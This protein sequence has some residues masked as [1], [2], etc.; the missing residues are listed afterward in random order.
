ME[1][2]FGIITNSKHKGGNV[3]RIQ[4]IINSIEQQNIPQYEIIIVGDCQCERRNTQIIPFDENQK[5]GWITRKK[6]IIT[7]EAK[8]ENIIYIHDY[9]L[10]ESNWYKGWLKFGN[11]W[12][13]AVNV[14]INTDNT[15]FRDWIIFDDPQ[16]TGHY[17]GWHK[18]FPEDNPILI[19]PN[20][21]PYDYKKVKHMYI[22]GSYWIAKRQVMMDNPL[23]ERLVWGLPEDINWSRRIRD[24]Y[25]IKMNTFSSVRL[26]QY[27][28]PVWRSN[29]PYYSSYEYIT[30]DLIK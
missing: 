18:D 6:N 25:N 2:T 28:D 23:D 9:I 1:F 19:S 5:Q 3:E 16:I 22:N 4:Q 30:K 27:K 11:N 12:D 29:N 17:I 21:P 14:I 8:Y 10:F 20:L 7:K 13:V 15:R 24:K 26:L